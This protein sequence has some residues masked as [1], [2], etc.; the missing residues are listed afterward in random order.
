[1]LAGRRQ[2]P[3]HFRA[4]TAIGRVAKEI[5]R[6]APELADELKLTGLELAFLPNRRDALNNLMKRVDIAPVR[7]LVTTLTQTER[8]GTPLARSLR[9]LA[10]E[11]R[12]VRMMRA[13]EKAARLP[14]VLTVPMIVFILPP[15]FTVLVGPAIIQVFSQLH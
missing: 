5:G 12:N 3:R 4:L 14:A 11:F 15:L 13:E 10:I 1:M 6:N 8:Y 9:M 2:F 7:N